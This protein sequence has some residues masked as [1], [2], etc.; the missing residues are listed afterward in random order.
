MV[1]QRTGLHRG[2]HYQFDDVIPRPVQRPIPVY[3][4]SFS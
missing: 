2:N 4:A 1:E 3:V